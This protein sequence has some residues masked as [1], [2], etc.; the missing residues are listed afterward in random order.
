[1][2]EDVKAIEITSENS[3]SVIIILPSHWGG[4]YH[5]IEEDPEQGDLYNEHRFLSKYEVELVYHIDLDDY[6]G[7]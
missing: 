4:H 3:P 1:M 7:G 5:V 2:I 6:F